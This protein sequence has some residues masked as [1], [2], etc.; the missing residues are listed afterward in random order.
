MDATIR[1]F[2]LSQAAGSEEFAN[3]WRAHG[4][5]W[6]EK[7][8]SPESIARLREIAKRTSTL[9]KKERAAAVTDAL[10][11]I[12]SGGF[13]DVAGAYGWDEMGDELPSLALVAFVEGATGM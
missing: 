7:D 8:A 4:R 5:Q 11:Q 6:A 3:F 10:K 2:R 9:G 12:W 13:S 1:R